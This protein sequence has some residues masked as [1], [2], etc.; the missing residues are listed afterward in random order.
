MVAD[1]HTG[2][3]SPLFGTCAASHEGSW[4]P[5]A[6]TR[7]RRLDHSLILVSI[8]KYVLLLHVP[9]TVVCV[10]RRP[11]RDALVRLH[12]V[13]HAPTVAALAAHLPGTRLRPRAT[14]PTSG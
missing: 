9:G 3:A 11:D 5:R 12:R 8:F 13:F 4:S 14:G 10:R 1:V 6:R 2:A 7:T